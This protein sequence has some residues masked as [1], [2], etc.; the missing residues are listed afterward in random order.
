M[1]LYLVLR[2]GGGG[3]ALAL[4]AHS[5]I[6]LTYKRLLFCFKRS[7]AGY[8]MTNVLQARSREFWWEVRTDTA[9]DLTLYKVQEGRR[10]VNIKEQDWL[11]PQ[12]VLLAVINT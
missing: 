11:T 9:A 3:A 4:V 10:G 2:G 6:Q 1:G 12:N 5:A 7:R 8:L